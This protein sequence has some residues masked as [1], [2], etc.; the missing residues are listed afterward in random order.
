M[1]GFPKEATH[2]SLRSGRRSMTA[3]TAGAGT[4]P[5]RIL[6]A[7]LLRL[8]RSGGIDR[9]LWCVDATISRAHASA[10]GAGGKPARG[11]L[12]A[13]RR[14]RKSSS[15]KAMRWAARGA[16]SAPRCTWSATAGAP[17]WPCG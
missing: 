3:S 2:V 16:A 15:L 6:D 17:S 10:A 5:G 4:A 11:R 1:G 13:A 14:R 12:W 9:E 7:L 8:D